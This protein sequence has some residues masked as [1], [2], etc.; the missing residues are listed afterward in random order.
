MIIT[1]Y[2]LF[3]FTVIKQY[4]G[5]INGIT[6]ISFADQMGIVLTEA[7][8]GFEV[9]DIGH[10]KVVAAWLIFILLQI[11]TSIIVLNTLIAIL[12][13]SYDNVMNEQV[14]Y[15][16]KQK[17]ELLIEL[18]DFYKSDSKNKKDDKEYIIMIRYVTNEMGGG[19]WEGK[20]KMITREIKN[21][22]TATD[23]KFK[24]MK[25]LQ[26]ENQAKIMEQFAQI[27]QALS[28]NKN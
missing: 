11:V 1:I 18:N 12:G 5:L 13:D 22:N 19:A 26:D 9:P 4:Q 7:L 14:A 21:L 8:G 28:E 20:I 15:D 10:D 25:Q 3:V 27:K 2:I 16:T 23:E 24:K 6:A 17:V